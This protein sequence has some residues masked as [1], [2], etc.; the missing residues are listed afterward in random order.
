MLSDGIVMFNKKPNGVKEYKFLYIWIDILGFR[1]DLNNP[2]IYEDLFK[3]REKF[4]DSFSEK[5]INAEAVISIS[6]GLVL[7]W[8]L[9]KLT[10]NEITRIFDTLGKLQMQFILEQKKVLRGAIA[11]GDVSSNLYRKFINNKSSQS[12]NQEELKDIFLISNGLVKAYIMESKDIK[13]PIIAT[14][15]EVLD[16]IRKL[17]EIEDKEEKFGLKKIKGNNH[18]NLYMIDFLLHL[19]EKL[20][21]YEDFLL[22]NLNKCVSYEENKGKSIFDKY[23]WLLEYLKR[24]HNITQEL[25]NKFYDGVLI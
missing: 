12:N 14:T 9:S 20:N 3:I 8:E 17:K 7:V 23:Y 19:G 1:E 15:D 18:F 6:D 25:F 5:E 16:E 4:K 10:S 21:Q 22:S 24:K 13:W 11:I 2:K